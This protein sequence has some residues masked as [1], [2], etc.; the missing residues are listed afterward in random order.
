MVRMILSLEYRAMGVAR[1]GM[2]VLLV[3]AHAQPDVASPGDLFDP[4]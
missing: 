2:P 1:L 3:G 4:R